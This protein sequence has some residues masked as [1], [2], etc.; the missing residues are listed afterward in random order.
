MKMVRG[1]YQRDKMSAGCQAN[2]MLYLV[3][4]ANIVL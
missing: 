1:L 2:F 3:W 4:L